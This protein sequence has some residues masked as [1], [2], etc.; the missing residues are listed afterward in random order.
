MKWPR[1]YCATH[2]K[3]KPVA[4]LLVSQTNM[5]KAYKVAKSKFYET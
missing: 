2:E 1:V 5:Q 3:Q 4:K